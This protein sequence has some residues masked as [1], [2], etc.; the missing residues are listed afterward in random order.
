MW[1]TLRYGIYFVL[2]ILIF[3]FTYK[4]RECYYIPFIQSGIDKLTNSELKFRNFSLKFPLTVILYD[5]N[6]KDELF[7]DTA[8][9]DFEPLILL[10]NIKN[11]FKSM[12][13]VN[14]DKLN[15]IKNDSSF[16]KTN[17]IN[18]NKNKKNFIIKYINNISSKANINK[19]NVIYSNNLLK[20]TDTEIVLE[21]KSLFVSTNISFKKSDISVYGNMELKDD[22]V[23]SNLQLSIDGKIK[24]EL[25]FNGKFNLTDNTFNY[26]IDADTLFISHLKI[27]KSKINLLKDTDKITVDYSGESGNMFFETKDSSF[28][29]WSSTGTITLSDT[30]DIATAKLK[31]NTY[32]NESFNMYAQ[33]ENITLLGNNIGNLDIN[34]VKNEEQFNFNCKHNLENEF[35][36]VVSSSGNYTV[37]VYNKEKKIGNAVGNYETSDLSIDMKNIPIKKIMFLSDLNKYVYGT[38]SLYGTVNSSSGTITL[39]AKNL[40]SKQLK[41]FDVVGNLTKDGSVWLC[42]IATQ[43]KKLEIN[44]SYESRKKS[45]IDFFFSD[46][47]SNNIFKILGWLNPKVSGSATGSIKYNTTD[48]ATIADIK[49][50][51]GT[52][53]NNT[54]KTWTI[55]SDISQNKINISTFSFIG[56]KSSINLTTLLDFNKNSP[57]SYINL[58]IKNFK[59]DDIKIDSQLDFIG[60]I[61]ENTDEISGKLNVKKLNLNGLNFEHTSNIFLSAKQLRINNI[62][63]DNNISGEL[64]YNFKNKK[65]SANIKAVQAKLSKYYSKVKGRL[66]LNFSVDG[67][68]NKPKIKAD[69]KVVNGLYNDS[70]PFD[71]NLKIT[72]RNNKTFL[73]NFKILFD[74][75]NYSSL[76]ASGKV[77]LEDNDIKIN[78]KN[79][80]HRNINRFVGFIT[81]FKGNFF[82]EGNITGKMKDLNCLLN[83]YSKEMFI[84]NIKFN[85]LNSKIELKKNSINITDSTIK[86]K[87]S[88]IQIVSGNFNVKS[89]IYS[90]VFKL[91]NTHIGP[92]D[93]FGTTYLNG[94]MIKKLNGSIYTGDILLKDFWLNRQKVNNLPVNYVINNK[95]FSFET[96]KKEKFKLQGNIDFNKYPNINLEKINISRDEQQFDVNGIVSSKD[97]DITASTEYVDADIITDI[98]NLPFDMQGPINMKLTAKGTV[99]NPSIDLIAK[100]RYGSIF[101][102][103]YSTLNLNIQSRDNIL[104]IKE[105]NINKKG[106]YKASITG[107]CPFWLDPSLRKKMLDKDI[108]IN[109]EL[110][111]DKCGILKEYTQDQISAKSGK[112]HLKGSLTGTLNKMISTGEL[113]ANISNITTNSYIQKIKNLIA[114]FKWEDNLLEIKKFTAKVGSG[115]VDIL[116][117][118]TLSGLSPKTYDLS[119]KTTDKGIPIVIQELP[120][121][122][123]GIFNMEKSQVLTNF[124]KAIPTFDFKLQGNSDNLKLTGWAKLENAKF[125]FPSPVKINKTS[126]FSIDDIFPNLFIDIDL[127]S[128]NSTNFENSFANLY[129]DG[130][131]NL[132]GPLDD[133]K[134][135]GIVESGEGRVSYVG[136]DFNVVN[137]KIEIIN[138]EIFITGEGESDV[139]SAGSNDA[140]TI[141]VFVD[142]SPTDNL[143]IR[144]A[145]K[146]DPT[147][148]SK[149]AL[150]RLTKTDPSQFT[151]LDTSTDFLV[152][153][154]AIRLLGSNVAMPLANTVLKKTGLVDNVRLGYVNQDNLE[155]KDD[156]EPTIAE[157]LYGMK[158]SVEKNINRLLQ[159]G[160]SVTF[161]QIEREIDLKHALEMSFKVNKDLFLKGSYGLNSDNPN[162]EPEKKVMLEQRL[163]FGGGKKK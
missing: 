58:D 81:P 45:N 79:F 13:A 41:K 137:S 103:F 17:K 124:S 160:Y 77:G 55:C 155:V 34:S 27:G 52:L 23:I 104:N 39:H 110:T 33:V 32:K 147:M 24:T 145:S 159:V 53:Y 71:L 5:I 132:K 94:K 29:V 54:F 61:S 86:L 42:N 92:F 69:C 149:T 115:T 135:N 51:N 30:N 156:E 20:A 152:K 151:T 8:T 3:S 36:V 28:S 65:I 7:I 37:D 107:N 73:D 122:T 78:I 89:G 95:K 43:D 119:M 134:A 142:R 1:K 97:I 10:K 22:T 83:I 131:I 15:F 60:A 101:N 74:K 87:D 162:Y 6:Y 146:N 16:E 64:T 153:Q 9:I 56:D 12:V 123:S 59:I 163:R 116:G 139:Y 158:Y 82:G 120:I 105:F 148:D 130:K 48:S 140:E 63:D 126:D 100:S 11:P 121:P 18:I 44:G 72:N 14:I 26:S 112:I 98:F 93:V 2:F 75:N 96:D 50:K 90:S 91:V 129:L 102:I 38:V 138:N 80:S 70:V 67:K 154:Q 66:N 25:D 141:K 108:N 85:D 47:D 31:Y 35:I 127:L 40:S 128:A 109:Y 118:I 136:N 143:K 144:F 46:I 111:D 88:E 84:K 49:L 113:N 76:T 68:L 106:E 99:S 161:D 4:F 19:I 57:Q 133:I 157:L 62:N 21:N 125:C 114:D 150:S 117:N